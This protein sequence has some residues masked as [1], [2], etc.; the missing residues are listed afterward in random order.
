MNRSVEMEA[1]LQDYRIQRTMLKREKL[2]KGCNY[3][4]E[5]FK[6]Q[7]ELL[8]DKQILRQQEKT[9]NAVKYIIFCNLLTSGYTHSYEIALGLADERLYLD[10][11]LNWAYWRPEYIYTE[12]DQDL[13]EMT[14]LLREKFVRIEQYELLYLQRRLLMDDWELFIEYL[15]KI[16]D[17]LLDRII[18]SQ[19]FLEQE[20]EILYGGYMEEPNAAYKIVIKEREEHKWEKVHFI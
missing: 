10:E 4:T 17:A 2:D 9:Q 15:S 20:L 8:I 14:R 7:V 16:S 18:D 3:Y 1:Y 6:K 11:K 12:M 5:S 19:L 13:K